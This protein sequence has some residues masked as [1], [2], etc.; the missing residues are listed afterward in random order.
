MLFDEVLLPL[1]DVT[2]LPW[3]PGRRPGKKLSFPTVWRWATKGLRG[4]DKTVIRLE[5]CRV[6][7]MLCTS[8]L[9]VRRFFEAL[10]EHDPNIAPAMIP[11][12]PA[13]RARASA[14]AAKILES[15]G[16]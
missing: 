2:R 15:K 5:T 16:I 11:R 7:G 9:A 10:T 8:E 1:R 12:S 14:R 6:G 4:K 13:A 3:I